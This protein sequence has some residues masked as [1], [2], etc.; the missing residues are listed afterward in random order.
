MGKTDKITVTK[1]EPGFS[2]SIDNL[3]RSNQITLAEFM[4]SGLAPHVNL[5][6]VMTAKRFKRFYV[7]PKIGYFGRLIS[8]NK[9]KIAL[10]GR[11][12]SGKSVAVHMYREHLLNDKFAG[13][14]RKY[15]QHGG[16]FVFDAEK[17]TGEVDDG[18]RIPIFSSEVHENL[19]TLIKTICKKIKSGLAAL[20]NFE[21][22]VIK[23]LASGDASITHS[24]FL[25]EIV[26]QRVDLADQE[27]GRIRLARIARDL[28]LTFNNLFEFFVLLLAYKNFDLNKN[29]DPHHK[30]KDNITFFVFDNLEDHQNNNITHI[31]TYYNK[32]IDRIKHRFDEL[33]RNGSSSVLAWETFSF[34]DQFKFVF[35]IRSTSTFLN[36]MENPQLDVREWEVVPSPDPSEIQYEFVKKKVKFLCSD[37]ATKATKAAFR[38]E[39]ELL[40]WLLT[41]VHN[42]KNKDC[43]SFFNFNFRAAMLMLCNTL[44][45]NENLKETILRVKNS[46]LPD[47]DQIKLSRKILFGALYRS[48]VNYLQGIGIRPIDAFRHL[49]TLNGAGYSFTRALLSALYWEQFCHDAFKQ[50]DFI[51]VSVRDLCANFLQ[52]NSNNTDRN[53]FNEKIFSEGIMNL[54]TLGMKEGVKWDG[55]LVEHCMCNAPVGQDPASPEICIPI[56]IDRNI[57]QN[58]I[59]LYNRYTA[60]SARIKLIETECGIG[61]THNLLALRNEQREIEDQDIYVKLSPAGKLF[62][63]F[64]SKNFEFFMARYEEQNQRVYHKTLFEYD[65]I[66]FVPADRSITGRPNNL[67]PEFLRP[68]KDVID[69]VKY[70]IVCNAN[71]IKAQCSRIKQE[72]QRDCETCRITQSLDS[73]DELLK[74]SIMIAHQEIYY[75][76]EECA[77]YLQKFSQLNPEARPVILGKIA[78]LRKLSQKLYGDGDQPRI[79]MSA[80]I[81]RHITDTFKR[82]RRNI[83]A[84]LLKKYLPP[85]CLTDNGQTVIKSF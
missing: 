79:N 77:D 68:V 12:G 41:P 22:N 55:Y 23:K 40:E 15:A 74:C 46:H 17:M 62:V 63:E 7:E 6:G 45:K 50:T 33:V 66:D 30:I 35:S 5:R 54:S 58:Q 1:E 64:T 52:T 70:F 57:I 72:D 82:M 48:E 71:V 59:S 42:D 16:L 65:T 19:Y 28:K 31:A 34:K 60:L 80:A 85:I 24:M 83:P 3:V 44:S 39:A 38:T 4:M 53:I 69:A 26:R 36:I 73:V 2:E 20:N 9:N 76:I 21:N 25:A 75:V 32:T 13:S 8:T 49:D 43:F 10:Y 18:G 37:E 78:E 67:E 61:T 29:T 47:A 84:D 14:K 81:E 27:T 51:G 56:R 11:R